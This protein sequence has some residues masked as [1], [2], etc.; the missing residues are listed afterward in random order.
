MHY[1]ISGL[2]PKPFV[3]LFGLADAAL[4]SLGVQRMIV[5]QSPGFPD[6]IELRDLNV[7]EHALLLNYT[8]QSAGTP[9][10]ASHAIFIAESARLAA[11]F[12]NEVP[13]VMQRRM[14]S[15]RAFDA[16]HMMLDAELIDGLQLERQIGQF[17]ARQQIA[18]LH[19]HYAKRGCFAGLVERG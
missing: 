19:V 10:R 6:R 13:L 4:Q 15:V 3:H 9:Y 16:Q 14:L 5:D 2:D 17:F 8:H 11:S 12:E 18:Y 7:G 1:R